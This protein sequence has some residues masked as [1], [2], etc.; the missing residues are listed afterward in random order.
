MRDQ[1]DR[2]EDEQD[3]QEHGDRRGV[4]LVERLEGADIDVGGDRVG[5]AGGP[6]LGHHEDQVG[7]GG[8][9]DRCAASR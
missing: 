1:D 8:D 9:P 5:R 3:Q 4:A 2:I 7:E 6:A